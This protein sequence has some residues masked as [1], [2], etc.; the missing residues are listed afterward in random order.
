MKV[1]TL[2]K[3]LKTLEQEREIRLYPKYAAERFRLTQYKF[4]KRYIQ[5]MI[6]S[7][8]DEEYYGILF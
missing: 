1:K 2:I 4:L 7:D 6:D 8:K 3:L 5:D